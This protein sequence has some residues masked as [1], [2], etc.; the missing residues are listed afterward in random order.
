MEG[1]IVYHISEYSTSSS[2]KTWKN[3]HKTVILSRERWWTELGEVRT[4][5]IL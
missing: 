3:I 2:T 1:N 4:G 5:N